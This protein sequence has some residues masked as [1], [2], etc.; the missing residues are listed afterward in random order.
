MSIVQ[1]YARFENPD[2]RPIVSGNSKQLLLKKQKGRADLDDIGR[3][4]APA[5]SESV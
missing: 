2:I 4:I 1:Q 3:D 5:D